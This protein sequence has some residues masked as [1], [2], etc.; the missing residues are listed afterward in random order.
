MAATIASGAIFMNEM[1]L[2]DGIRMNAR[3]VQHRRQLGVRCLL[4]ILG[5]IQQIRFVVAQTNL[6]V[7]K[8]G[9]L[10]QRCRFAIAVYLQGAICA[11]WCSNRI[12]PFIRQVQWSCINHSTAS[13]LRQIQPLSRSRPEDQRLTARPT[14][15]KHRKTAL[16][17][18]R[19][20]AFADFNPRSAFKL[21][22]PQAKCDIDD[23][24][25]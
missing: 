16:E 15:T 13:S 18:T 2:R 4:A 7:G 12:L 10:V 11:I 19:R 23:R 21:S 8:S 9:Y 5:A 6:D 20:R 25:I 1:T 17:S 22:N 24:D 14:A 3:F